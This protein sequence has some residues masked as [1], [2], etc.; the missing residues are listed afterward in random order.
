MTFETSVQRQFAKMLYRTDN[1]CDNRLGCEVP[2]AG[3]LAMNFGNLFARNIRPEIT[4]LA[5]Y[6]QELAGDNEMPRRSE[7]DPSRI[8]AICDY[9]YVFDYLRDQNDYR[10]SYSGARMPTLFGYE[11]MGV[12]LSEF[13]D[14]EL[15]MA[16][17]RSYDRVVETK[18]PLFMRARYAWPGKKSV[19]IER[20]VMPMAADD[21]EINAICGISIPE[22]A[23]VDIEMYTGQGPARLISEDDL[24][25][26]AS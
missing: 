14:P 26:M 24:M 20:L 8:W 17:R 10:G 19:S 5:R 23:D 21:G 2:D 12:L 7:F 6:A 1:S 25:L 9:V 18:K 16:L 3:V 4:G 11:L 15:G 13:P 22:V